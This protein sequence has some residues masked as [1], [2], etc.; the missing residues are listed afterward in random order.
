MALWWQTE[1]CGRAGQYGWIGGF[2]LGGALW[3]SGCDH[4]NFLMR[5]GGECQ[6]RI[7]DEA[8]AL[9]ADDPAG[10]RQV[11]EGRAEVAI[12]APCDHFPRGIRPFD[13]APEPGVIGA[14]IPDPARSRDGAVA[15]RLRRV[16][17]VLVVD[18]QIDAALAEIGDHGVGFGQIEPAPVAPDHRPGRKQMHPFGRTPARGKGPITDSEGKTRHGV[19]RSNRA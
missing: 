3:G 13:A 6:V 7:V 1:D 9:Q 17:L 14:Q 5:E 4:V 15:L 2:V 19:T 18:R 10:F 11:G 8:R 16:V 12:L